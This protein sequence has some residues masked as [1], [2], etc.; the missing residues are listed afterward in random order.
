[1]TV[2]LKNSP[3][4][5]HARDIC[6]HLSWKHTWITGGYGGNALARV[7][8]VHMDR[9]WMGILQLLLLRLCFVIFM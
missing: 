2:E 6:E 7:T 8:R 4:F 3:T 5:T 1:V 9:V